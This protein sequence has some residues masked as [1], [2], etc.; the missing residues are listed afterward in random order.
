MYLISPAVF[1]AGKIA[2][3]D[4]IPEFFARAQVAPAEHKRG[5][6][7]SGMP[8]AAGP[9]WQLDLRKNARVF[10]KMAKIPPPIYGHLSG[11]L[12]NLA[13]KSATSQK[14]RHGRLCSGRSS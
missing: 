1:P 13:K 2:N 7:L 3:D 6:E 12:G 8:L 14:E 9:L 4:S 5:R 11:K 10:A